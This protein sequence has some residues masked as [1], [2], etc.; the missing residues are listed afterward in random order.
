[1]AC[2]IPHQS[3]LQN[4]ALD[5]KLA[6]AARQRRLAANITRMGDGPMGWTGAD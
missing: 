4:V 6:S 3:E 2:A 1:M 5:L